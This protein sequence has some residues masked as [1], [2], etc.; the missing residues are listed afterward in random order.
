MLQFI[1]DAPFKYQMYLL[2]LLFGLYRGKQQGRE[3]ETKGFINPKK[4]S[5][6]V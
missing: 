2:L 4:E 3:R 5:F 1:S 6:T